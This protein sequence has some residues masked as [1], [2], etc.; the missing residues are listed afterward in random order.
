M[1]MTPPNAISRLIAGGSWSTTCAG[2]AVS[3][4]NWYKITAINGVTILSKYGV[5]YAY[6][7][8]GLVKVTT[9]ATPA[10]TATRATPP[11]AWSFLLVH[12]LEVHVPEVRVVVA[13]RHDVV[14]GEHRRHH[15]VILV[16]VLE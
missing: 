15:R 2:A 14:H 6:V 16:V 13:A 10:P 11:R 1:A 4:S 3:G 9:V 8:T 7:A 5:T 12:H